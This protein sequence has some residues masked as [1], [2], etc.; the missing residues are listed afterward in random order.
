MNC[1]VYLHVDPRDGSVRYIGKGSKGRAWACGFSKSAKAKGSGRYGNRTEEHNDWINGLLAE[2]YIPSDW[3]QIVRAK[4]TSAEA[5]RLEKQLIKVSEQSK[6]LFNI[7]DTSVK[8][9][10]L[11]ED[12]F[13][14]A[15]SLRAQGMSYDNIAQQLGVSVMPL[16]RALKGQTKGYQKWAN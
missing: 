9:K 11:S 13:R 8:C 7:T 1:Y 14:E 3:V 12:A 5:L 15:Q 16:Y 2:G 10:A 4:L 6:L